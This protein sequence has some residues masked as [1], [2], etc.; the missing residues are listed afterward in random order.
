MNRE[1]KMCLTKKLVNFAVRI[2]DKLIPKAEATYPQTQMIEHVFKKLSRAYAVEV[3]AGRFDDVPYQTLSNLKDRNFQQFL[4]LSEKLL[5]YLGENDRY[6][7][8]W[9]G[10]ALLLA[11][12]EVKAELER[13]SMEDFLTLTKAQ[14][15]FNMLGAFPK[16]YFMAHKQD[17][18]NILLANFLTNLA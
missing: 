2:L 16:E 11:E 10:Y 14:W 18:L 12:D 13:L 7:R 6:Y 1:L 9:L 4:N 5:V 17:F 8:Q 15:E 3:Y